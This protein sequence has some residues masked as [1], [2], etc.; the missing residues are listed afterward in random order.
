MGKINYKENLDSVFSL[1]IRYRDVMDNGY[2]KCI[3]CG[4]VK[5]FGQFENGHFIPRGNLST[6]FNEDNCNSQCRICNEYKSGD[7]VNYR[8]NLIKKIGNERVLELE[9]LKNVSGKYSEQEY[10][11][12]IKKYRALNRKLKKEKGI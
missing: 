12:L 6:R 11:S 5:P 10:K 9:R 8:H 1:F 4:E 3:S 2:I 7:L